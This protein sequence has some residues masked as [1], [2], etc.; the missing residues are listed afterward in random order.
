MCAVVF[1]AE[2]AQWASAHILRSGLLRRMCAQ[3]FLVLPGTTLPVRT[4]QVFNMGEERRWTAFQGASTSGASRGLED[5]G[6]VPVD[7]QLTSSCSKPSSRESTCD[8]I[9]SN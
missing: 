1:C 5:D 3:R 7:M 9:D 8:H 6:A 4:A 2:C